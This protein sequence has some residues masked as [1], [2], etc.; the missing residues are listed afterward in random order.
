MSEVALEYS[1]CV[2]SEK[3]QKELYFRRFVSDN[4]LSRMM[5]KRCSALMKEKPVFENM[6]IGLIAYPALKWQLNTQSVLEIIERILSA[7]KYTEESV[8][9]RGTRTVV[10]SV[11][12]CPLEDIPKNKREFLR[13]C[14]RITDMVEQ[15]S[16][17][18]ITCPGD[19]YIYDAIMKVFMT[20]DDIVPTR[21]YIDLCFSDFIRMLHNEYGPTFDEEVSKI[22][23]C[24]LEN[25]F[26]S[27]SVESKRNNAA[28]A[29][30]KEF[31]C[32]RWRISTF[33]EDPDYYLN[34]DEDVLKA[35]FERDKSFRE[36][37]LIIQYFRLLD[38]LVAIV[39]EFPYEGEDYVSV[40]DSV[41]SDKPKKK[42][43]LAI[44]QKLSMSTFSFSI[45]RR[46]AMM[47]LGE[48]LNGTN[49]DYYLDFM[50]GRV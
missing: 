22:R 44:C 48:A 3:E 33:C 45:K 20:A 19:G 8:R 25:V 15:I 32:L 43:D 35:K 2:K 14:R 24:P 18:V 6:L 4:S 40:L 21:Y 12:Q 30:L 29:L 10:E 5:G 23:T 50:M 16:K 9:L 41:I 17:T 1:S 39:G 28:M 37:Y 46:R 49:I 47:L 27:R 11:A 34:A 31:S 26:M 36:M 42:P 38:E 7:E 13:S